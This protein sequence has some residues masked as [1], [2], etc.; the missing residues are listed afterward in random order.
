MEE[1]RRHGPGLSG[2]VRVAREGFLEVCP[3]LRHRT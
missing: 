1:Q 2:S 3:A